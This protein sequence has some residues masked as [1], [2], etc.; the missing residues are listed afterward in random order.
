[1]I[2][3]AS[4]CGVELIDFLPDLRGFVSFELDMNAITGLVLE[5]GEWRRYSVDK[6][7]CAATTSQF[8][9]ST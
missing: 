2:P 5:S 8:K 9:D 4:F 6:V 7:E 3:L 1:M